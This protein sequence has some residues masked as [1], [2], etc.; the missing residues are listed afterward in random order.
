MILEGSIIRI[1]NN[2]GEY[3]IGCSMPRDNRTVGEYVNK[4]Y[5]PLLVDLPRQKQLPA[6]QVQKNQAL[7]AKYKLRYVPTIVVTD[8]DGKELGR[9]G[10]NTPDS[11]LKFLKKY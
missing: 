1:S 5:I 6:E 7:S 9:T 10:F 2:D 11:F 4:N 8:A 3:V